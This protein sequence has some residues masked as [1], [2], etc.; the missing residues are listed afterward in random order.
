MANFATAALVK[1]QT[2]LIGQFQ[3][4]ELRFRDPAV[5]KLFLRNT[6]IMLPDYQSLRTRDDR[7]IET[8]YFN[9]T[10]RSLGSARSHDHTGAQGDSSLL[11]P[12]W[13][14]YTD[15]FVSTI[16]EADNKIYSL[17]EL[18]MSK[19]ENVI[20]NFAEGLETVAST[21]LFANRSGVNVSTAEGSFDATDDTFEIVKSTNIDRAIQITRMNMDINGYQGVGFTMVCDSISFAL[22][23]FQ[24]AQGSSNATN[25]SFQFQGIEFL[26][27]PTLTAAAAGL[28]SVYVAGYW[29]A[30]PE[31]SV[32]ALSWIRVQNRMGVDF[33]NIAKYGQI[34][35]PVDN[36]A[37]ALHTY[38]EGSN[39]TSD[40]G[41]T[42]D[43][44]IETEI[45]V[46]IAYETVPLTTSTESSLMAFALV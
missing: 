19:M 30:V 3:A 31:G 18:H 35:N 28:A 23:Q 17:E 7:V 14:T 33:G 15:K 40:G 29:I 34:M 43:V 36:V 9:R 4:G 42:Q 1:A 16:K 46:D 26:H 44:T 45:S 6:N 38:S 12:S 41:Y 5:H 24:A 2:I 20:A 27:D 25:T 22:F 32:A 13:T 11:T 39:G 37:Y 8:N 10:S 21:F